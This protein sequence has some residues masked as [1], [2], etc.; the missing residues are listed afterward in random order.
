MTEAIKLAVFSGLAIG[1]LIAVSMLKKE[2]REGEKLALFW[3]IAAIAIFTT[4]YLVG[5]TI[6]K[7][8]ISLTGGPVHW[9]ADFEIYACGEKVE[10][11]SPEGLSN[12]IGSSDFHEHGDNRIHVEGVVKSYADV[13]L[14]KFFETV[15]GRMEKNYLKIPT[16]R[17]EI[18]FQDGMACASGETGIWQTFVYRTKNQTAWQEKLS[19]PQNYVL[20]P[21]S[22]VPP[23][24]CIVMEFG[25]PKD[26]IDRLCEFYEIAHKKGELKLSP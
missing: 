24:D 18:I 2:H 1:V 26:K 5:G 21:E 16:D 19:D 6:A 22:Q 7:N 8:R 11:K 9:H 17:G 25:A 15:G 4:F 13:T 20:S 12:R 10:L 3:S 23:G 14:Q